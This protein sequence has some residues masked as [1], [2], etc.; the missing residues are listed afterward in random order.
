MPQA[1]GDQE[2]DHRT[3]QQRQ[4][5]AGGDKGEIGLKGHGMIRW[6][7]DLVIMHGRM[8]DGRRELLLPLPVLHGERVGVRGYLGG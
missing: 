2:R 6:E 7:S 1:V 4:R 5:D 3:R 8:A